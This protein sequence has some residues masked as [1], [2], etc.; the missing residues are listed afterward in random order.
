MHGSHLR[1][2]LSPFVARL[3]A[4]EHLNLARNELSGVLPSELALLTA[5]T[6]LDLSNSCALLWALFVF[7]H[8][9]D[10]L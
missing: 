2:T 8:A 3:S 9:C 5:L 6:L 4:L 1:G 7:S 10:S